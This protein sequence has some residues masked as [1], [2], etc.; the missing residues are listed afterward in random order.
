M[1]TAGHY[2]CTPENDDNPSTGYGATGYCCNEDLFSAYSSMDQLRCDTGDRCTI[3]VPRDDENPETAET[4]TGAEAALYMTYTTGVKTWFDRACPGEFKTGVDGRKTILNVQDGG[5]LYEDVDTVQACYWEIK[6]PIKE[7]YYVEDES[8]VTFVLETADNAEVYIYEGS[9]RASAVSIIE[10]GDKLYPGN[11]LR[12]THLEDLLVVFRKA[13][14]GQSVNVAGV[15][16]QYETFDGSFSLTY[17]VS[18]HQYS[19]W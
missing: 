6:S 17:E 19:F 5:T 10:F 14:N 4:L 16:E 1:V 3:T 2:F 18:G 15:G 11:P 13:Q 8:E 12:I 9:D 7:D